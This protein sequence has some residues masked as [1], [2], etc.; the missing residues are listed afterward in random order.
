[1]FEE[2]NPHLDA[3]ISA[4]YMSKAIVVGDRAL[5]LHIWDTAGQ[6]KVKPERKYNW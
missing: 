1:V 6:E 2:F 5:M 3:T 4:V